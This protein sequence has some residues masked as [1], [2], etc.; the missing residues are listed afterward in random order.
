VRLQGTRGETVY[1][2]EG[3][4]LLARS[5]DGRFEPVGR[6]PAPRGGLSEATTVALSTPGLRRVTALLVGTVATV[7]TWP[8]TETDL[9]GTV[10]QSVCVSADGGGRWERTHELPSSSGPMGVLPSAVT[11]REGRTYLGEYP[12]ET[13]ATPRVLVS[14]DYGR[15]WATAL[16]LPDVR[17]VHAVQFDP[18]GGDLW[19]TTGDTDAQSHIGRLRG[20]SF[21]PVGGGSQRWRAVQLAFTP[22]AILWGMD[23]SYAGENHVFKLPRSELGSSSPAIEPVHAVPGSVYY[24]ATPTVDGETWAVFSTA[25]EAG[26]DRTGPA[27]QTAGD[28]PGVVVAAA[29]S[30]GYSE[31]HE[32]AAYERGRCVAD[33]LPAT[34]PRANGYV[35][36]GV[37]PDG[38]LMVNPYNTRTDDGDVYRLDAARKSRRRQIA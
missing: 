38:S 32:I 5:G 34:L 4:R 9:L 29:A 6:L 28:T 10:G 8:L 20:G 25:M 1:A 37:D 18:Y 21:D 2:T 35:F 36:L 14:D 3:R 7:N 12:L 26:R 33:Y 11:H 23:C 16:E 13:D 15:S 24:A 17:H 19:L 30:T 31:W 22:E 27:G